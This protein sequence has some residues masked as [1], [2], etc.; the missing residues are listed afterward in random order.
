MPRHGPEAVLSGWRGA[1][2]VPERSA[3]WHE[4]GAA[5]VAGELL[6]SGVGV[7]A[8]LWT[9]TAV[10]AWLASPL[11]HRC[12]RVLLEL[13]DGLEDAVTVREIDH[14]LAL[15]TAGGN[16]LPIALHGEGSS[17]WPDRPGHVVAAR[18]VSVRAA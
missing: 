8:G 18:A 16:A 7:E 12:D 1:E 9:G 6:G 2:G 5:E 13:P 10:G 11:R 4:D 15:L 17:C 3:T 14:L